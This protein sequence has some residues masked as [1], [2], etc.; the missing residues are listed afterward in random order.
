MTTDYDPDSFRMS[1]GEH[2]EELRRRLILALVGFGIA[3][4]FCLYFGR[5]VIMPTFCAPLATTLQKYNLPPQLRSNELPDVFNSYIYIS[6]ISA[7]AIASPWIVWQFWQFVA[8]GLYPNE[9]RLVTRFVP[10]SIGL[11]ISGMLFVYYLVL[12]WTLEFFIAFAIGVPLIADNP[13]PAA[14]TQPA[15]GSTFIQVV[16]GRPAGISEGQ[17]W[18]DQLTR[19]VEAVFGGEI[20]VVRFSADNLIATDYTLNSYIDLVVGMLIVF[21]L[22]FQLPL[23]VMGLARM[24]ILTIEGLKSARRYVYFALAI[25]AAAITPGDMITASVALMLPLALLYELGIWLAAAGGS[26][27]GT[28]QSQP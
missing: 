5:T 10:L 27:R 28:E 9:R 26:A 19:R 18:Y 2:L 4:A 3:C 14:A 16:N 23:V 21:G 24:G 12:P 13:L 1:I 8:A 15:T 11:L 25:L 22:S 20:R 17:I 7:T 6:L